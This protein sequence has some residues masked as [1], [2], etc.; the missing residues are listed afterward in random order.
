MVKIKIDGETFFAGEGEKLSDILISNK[1]SVAHPCGGRG[2]CRK[3]TV[4]IDGKKELSCQYKVTKDIEVSLEKESEILSE[5]G[6]EESKQITENLCFVLDIGT[7]TLSLALVSLD[8]KRIVKVFT[9]TNPQR[10]F[11]AD[12][13]TRIDYCRKNGVNEL[14]EILVS[15]INKMINDFGI[16]EIEK[17]YVSGNTT[18]LHIF[19]GVDCSSMGVAPYSPVFL[20]S[21]QIKTDKIKGVGEIISL[22]CISSFVGADLVAGLNFIEK[23][24]KEK[25]NLLIDLGTNAEI[26]L[27]SADRILCTSA[28]AGPCFEGGNISCGMCATDGAIY[29]YGRGRIET[30]SNAT[31]KGICGTGLVDIIAELLSDGTIDETGFMECEEYEIAENISLTQEDV[32][33][34]QLAKSAVYSAV[35]ALIKNESITFADIEKVYISGGF[36]AKINISNA[37]RTGLI[38]KELKDKCVPINNSSLLGTVKYALEK[39]DLSVFTENSEYIN[40]SSDKYFS[41]LFME[42]MMF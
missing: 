4:F 25:Y 15:G 31:A 13:I 8:E 14:Q 9:R 10:I 36:S 41:D 42:N 35:L 33:Q 39:N 2:V 11:G 24:Q 1:K 21:K 20:E 26:V 16:S 23:P 32:R 27:Y 19:F 17:M 30:I 7:T 18:M 22:P 37:V 28:A 5:T 6:T 34:Y 29:A 38:P 3:C 40:L 12:V